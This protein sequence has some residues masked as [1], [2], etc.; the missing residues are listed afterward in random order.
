MAQNARKGWFVAKER[1]EEKFSGNAAKFYSQEGSGYEKNSIK[2]IQS[3][4]LLR[5][6]QLVNFPS[7]S[8]LLDVGCGTGLGMEIL[9]ELGFKVQGIDVSPDLLKIAK[10]KKLKVM[11]GDMRKMPIKD[12]QFDGIVSISALQWVI[13]KDG[14]EGKRDVQV[15]ADEFF[16]VLTPKGKAIIQFYP[17]SEDEAMHAGKAFKIAGFK[18]TLQIDNENNAKK[19]KVYLL[20]EKKR[21]K[22]KKEKVGLSLQLPNSQLDPA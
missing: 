2:N 5:G 21:E 6:L 14:A 10:A 17:K 13:G 12:L 20:L 19:R 4:I 1:P 8:K 22:N 9:K 7:N 18:A 11:L 15:V 3:K 16:R